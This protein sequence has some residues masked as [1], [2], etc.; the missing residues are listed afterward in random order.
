MFLIYRIFSHTAAGIIVHAKNFR[1]ANYQ[2]EQKITAVYVDLNLS[3]SRN[4]KNI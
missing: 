2:T 4:R 3:S 1:D